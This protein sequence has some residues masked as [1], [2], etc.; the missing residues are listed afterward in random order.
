MIMRSRL[1]THGQHQYK[2][3]GSLSNYTKARVIKES[4]LV[5]VYRGC[6]KKIEQD[7][8]LPG[9]TSAQA[10]KNMAKT[11]ATLLRYMDEKHPNEFRAAR[12]ASYTVPNM[13]DK[14][15]VA[16]TTAKGQP[17]QVE[18]ADEFESFDLEFADLFNS[19]GDVVA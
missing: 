18:G 15:Q 2:W 12:T 11:F 16:Y 9:L 19:L 14:G 17:I 8:H 1:S 4:P 10:K 6:Q 5:E 3:G 7:L 13:L